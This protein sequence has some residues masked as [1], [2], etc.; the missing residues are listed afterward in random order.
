MYYIEK[1]IIAVISNVIIISLDTGRVR[2]GWCVPIATDVKDVH[3]KLL[4]VGMIET[5][6]GNSGNCFLA[7]YL[8][9]FAKLMELFTQW[10]ELWWIDPLYIQIS[11]L[12]VFKPYLVLPHLSSLS[13]QTVRQPSGKEF[14]TYIKQKLFISMIFY[15]K[16]L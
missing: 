16:N 13:L 11:T 6:F 3:L 5:V 10:L 4:Y 14:L 9:S 12:D 15:I 7:G 1:L 8:W 2:T